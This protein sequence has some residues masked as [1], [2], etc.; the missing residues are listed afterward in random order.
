MHR[1]LLGVLVAK[2]GAAEGRAKQ[3]ELPGMVDAQARGEK[4]A[5]QVRVGTPE[6]GE[7]TLA[8]VQV[9]PDLAGS[10]HETA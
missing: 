5:V 10:I 4:A 8:H 3:N 6:R 1:T 2:A 7:L 9:E